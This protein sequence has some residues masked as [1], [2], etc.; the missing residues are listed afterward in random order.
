MAD[1]AED[2]IRQCDEHWKKGYCAVRAIPAA[3]PHKGGAIVSMV[4]RSQLMGAAHG[5]RDDA[6]NR[7]DE[8][9]KALRSVQRSVADGVRGSGNLNPLTDAELMQDLAILMAA[10]LVL[11]PEIALQGSSLETI[12]LWIHPDASL[13]WQER[14]LLDPEIVPA[15]PEPERTVH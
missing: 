8:M 14:G 11:G 12:G 15:P 2:A 4:P 7:P 13:P 9:A 6:I 5:F 3:G 10:A 1:N